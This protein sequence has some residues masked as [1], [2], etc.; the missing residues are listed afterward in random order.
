MQFILMFYNL[1]QSL[2]EGLPFSAVLLTTVDVSFID[3]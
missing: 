3:S 2:I 1:Y